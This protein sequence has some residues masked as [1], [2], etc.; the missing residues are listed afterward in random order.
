M[1]DGVKQIHNLLIM[2]LSGSAYNIRLEVKEDCVIEGGKEEYSKIY[3]Y[4]FFP[5]NE[6]AKQWETI[7]QIRDAGASQNHCK[8]F[9]C[10]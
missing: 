4:D 8:I 5:T 1:S 2:T 7:I 9:L 10:S 3:I 6:S